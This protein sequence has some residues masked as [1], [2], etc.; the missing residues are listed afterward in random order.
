M[1]ALLLLA[2]GCLTVSSLPVFH[3]EL[4]SIDDLE[5]DDEAMFEKAKAAAMAAK[6]SAD[7]A[8]AIKLDEAEKDDEAMIAEAVVVTMAAKKRGDEEE[9]KQ[10]EIFKAGFLMGKESSDPEPKRE[11]GKKKKKAKKA[12]KTKETKK[13]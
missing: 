11:R 12:K 9:A 2:A 4:E 13:P 3:D 6:K 5:G 8:E 10:D 1:G 7:E